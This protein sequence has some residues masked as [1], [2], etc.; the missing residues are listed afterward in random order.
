MRNYE[1]FKSGNYN[2]SNCNNYS[3][4]YSGVMNSEFHGSYSSHEDYSG[5]KSERF[6]Y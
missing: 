5:E 3:A 2:C 1:N 4:S 6:G